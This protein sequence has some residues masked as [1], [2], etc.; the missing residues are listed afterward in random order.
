MDHLD[1]AIPAMTTRHVHRLVA[2]VALAL[3]GCSAA[4]GSSAPGNG[5]GFNIADA[6]VVARGGSSSAGNG[7]YY[8]MGGSTGGGGI[9]VLVDAGLPRGD[10]GRG[11]PIPSNLSSD[12]P[13]FGADGCA[14]CKPDAAISMD[15]PFMA[16]GG[17]GPD[18][19]LPVG[20]A[21]GSAGATGSGGTTSASGG[22]SGRGGSEGFGGSSSASL[23]GSPGT[24]GSTGIGGAAGTGGSGADAGAGPDAILVSDAG[25]DTGA[26]AIP[27]SCVARIRA[28]VPATDSLDAFDN[29][30]AGPNV[31]VVLRAEVASLG[32]LPPVW[33]W[34]CT[35]DGTPVTNV[36]LGQQDSAVAA[37]L[38]AS[39]GTYTFTARDKTGAC[40]ARVQAGAA[41]A[42]DCPDCDRAVLLH[43]APSSSSDLPV[44][45]GFRTLSGFSPFS[46]TTIIPAVGVAARI[47][48]SVN[49]N[50]VDAYVRV[51]Q[52]GGKLITDGLAAKSSGSGFSVDVVSTDSHGKVQYY[53]VLVVPI[54]GINDSTIAATAPQL[55]TALTAGDISRTSFSLS[56]GV[57]VTGTVTDAGGS[58]VTDARVILSNRNPALP[59]PSSSLIFSSVGRSDAQGKFVLHAQ[60]GTYWISISPPSGAGLAEAL[61][62]YPVSL[63]GDTTLSFRWDVPSTA[64]VALTVVDAVGMP[65]PIGSRVR[66]ASAGSSKV[67]TLTLG[68]SSQPAQGNVQ[69]QGTTSS[70]GAVRFANVPDGTTYSVLLA[71]S[72][73]GPSAATT[74]LSLTV[75]AGG[76]TQTVQLLPQG[77]IQGQL[78]ASL[79]TDWTQVSVVAYDRSDDSPEAP[80]SIPA[81]ADGRFSMPVSPGRPYAVLAVPSTGSGLART[82][83]GPGFLAA[84]EF[85]IKQKVLSSMPWISTAYQTGYDLS[86]TALQVLCGAGYAGCVDPTIPLAETTI[87]GGA[88]ELTLPDPATR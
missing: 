14:S 66:L 81:S 39:P 38:I 45:D 10:A 63:S 70:S 5:G 27:S 12:G 84:S 34:Q 13:V 41:G 80:F 52:T 20:G 16:D 44:Q 26:D 31:Q 72:T 49:G 85:T 11:E 50:R 58:A 54:D 57:S 82:F 18:A 15:A 79:T 60:P 74:V 25:A 40:I 51:S 43:I 22:G 4:S 59:G 73:L 6:G 87:E 42:N 64:V 62:P 28:I 68:S 86:G 3:I 21:G 71:P 78:S 67:G 55:F 77:S 32:P 61:V 46:S 19:S 83:V 56:G 69:A 30:F 76:T 9:A 1:S 35:R 47:A 88:F 48:P 33:G 8:G 65:P 37:F 17:R 36:V 29:L 23:G 2:V 53:D 75:P 7:G 24:G